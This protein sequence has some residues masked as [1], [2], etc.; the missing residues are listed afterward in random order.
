MKVDLKT[1]S[2]GRL[3]LKKLLNEQQFRLQLS[4]LRGNALRRRES[5][6]TVDFEGPEIISLSP[7]KA[8]EI[9][10]VIGEIDPERKTILGIHNHP[11]WG[12]TETFDF[13]SEQDL[14]GISTGQIKGLVS[15]PNNKSLL[16]LLA[17]AR[18]PR[19]AMDFDPFW[20]KQA[21]QVIARDFISQRKMFGSSK[22]SIPP[23]RLEATWMRTAVFGLIAKGLNAAAVWYDVADD[24]RPTLTPHVFQLHRIFSKLTISLDWLERIDRLDEQRI[25]KELEGMFDDK[26]L[27]DA[28]QDRNEQRLAEEA[29]KNANINFPYET[30]REVG[31]TDYAR[32]KKLVYALRE[33]NPDISRPLRYEL[34][35]QMIKNGTIEAMPIYVKG[36]LSFADFAL[37]GSALTQLE[38]LHV[39]TLYDVAVGLDVHYEKARQ[40]LESGQIAPDFVIEYDGEKE[41]IFLS[42]PGIRT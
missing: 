39:Y 20:F 9:T 22:E 11:A 3:P 18:S 13:F 42:V 36:E 24:N 31:L 14:S 25:E 17:Q 5:A 21:Y 16:L 40:M 8:G 2:S 1:S 23:E 38:K 26:D 15:V 29:N 4:Q 27:T 19:K 35:K 32:A 10:S 6:F 34:A 37:G 28:E 41:L 30:A 7:V 12:K 33:K